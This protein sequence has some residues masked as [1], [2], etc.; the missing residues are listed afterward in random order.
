M[1]IEHY[2]KSVEA[3][4]TYLPEIL[5][6]QVNDPNRFDYG[7]IEKPNLGLADSSYGIDELL[8]CYFCP[9]S[10]Y[11]RSNDLKERIIKATRFLV[12][13]QH[14]DGT[15]DL[16]ETNFSSP[17]DTS[18]RVWFYGPWVEY[19]RKIEL[20]DSEME[21]LSNLE[22]FL[23]RAM[24]ALKSGGFHTPNHRWVQASALARLGRLFNDKECKDIAKEYLE[25]GIDCNEDGL[26][27]ERSL[28][29][30]NP[31]CGK[32]MLW[33]SEDLDKDLIR[34]TKKVLDFAIHFLEKDG[35]LLNTF[36]TRQD[37]GLRLSA[38][39]N[40]YYLYKK[41]GILENNGIYAEASDC[42]FNGNLYRLGRGFNPLQLFLFYPELKEEGVE[43]KS[44]P[45]FEKR[46]F[47]D[48]GILRVNSG[49][50][51]LTL[52]KGSDEFLT[53]VLRDID[54]RFRYLTSFFGK[55][56]FVGEEIKEIEDGYII[57]QRIDWG[58]IDLLPKE[59]RGKNIMW[60]AMNHSLRKWVKLQ[61]IE[62][63]IRLNIDNNLQSGTINI[64]TDGCGNVLTMLEI[65]I[66][67]DGEVTF[68]G[69]VTR[70]RDGIY[71]LRDGLVRYKKDNI[72]FELGPGSEGHRLIDYRGD[73]SNR[74][75]NRLYIVMTFRTPF[76]HRLNFY[77]NS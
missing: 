18:F 46:F 43:R 45:R 44:L 13:T 76:E 37:R 42:I 73:R 75:S 1:S 34:Y 67:K 15:I 40:Y 20:D 5:R 51:S 31:I 16:Y 9:D 58:Y 74:D 77:Y 57:S 60:N 30:Y 71:L 39:T 26:F 19:L 61:H 66:P 32:A 70:L 14:E 41:M 28:A 68:N 17:P 64:S 8:C 24:S 65:S 23:K 55:G 35:S 47:K 56:P 22:L 7:G 29:I 50:N 10:K 11:Y 21:I 36:S 53:L 52:T 54:I 27:S 48:S 3:L 38:D 25:E 33:L 4:D 62:T 49:N 2:L 59:E 12:R 63:K 69:E 72:S 6:R